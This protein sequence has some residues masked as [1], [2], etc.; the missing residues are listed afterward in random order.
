MRAGGILILGGACTRNIYDGVAE[1]TARVFPAPTG[2]SHGRF[3]LVEDDGVS[4]DH[5][6]KGAYTE[7]VVSFAAAGGDRDS[8]VV[9]DCE[10]VRGAYELPYDVIWFEL[11]V[12]NARRVVV[13]EGKEERRRINGGREVGLW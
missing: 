1:R 7:L 11:P 6:G 13:K 4:N 12:G 8:E 9:V 2:A 5:T 10:V 3:T